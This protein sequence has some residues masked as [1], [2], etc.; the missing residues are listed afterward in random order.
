[1]VAG[2]R[3]GAGDGAVGRVICYASRTGTRRNLVALAEAG[4]RLLV[5]PHGEWRSEGLPYAI[6][7]GAWTA[8]Q[9]GRPI[10]LGLFAA[11]VERMGAGADWIVVPDIVAGGRDSL[12]LSEEWLP[13]LS[14]LRL[15][16]VQDGMTTDDVRPLLGPEVGL[17][18]G[19]ST[20]W[21]LATM[22]DW[23]RLAADL[24]CYYHVARVNTM[25]RIFLA[26][27]AGADSVDGTSVTRY[28]VNL[29]KLD[30]AA[31]QYQ[32]REVEP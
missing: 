10:D 27:E 21:K 5:S 23:G 12:R 24:G 31:R 1:M 25:R 30:A 22:R 14:G 8:Y 17:F 28:V 16:A 3:G 11:L 29:R 4:W 15:I 26:T 20:E 2:R 6:D 19:G 32:L 9:S 18:L 7:N 13:R